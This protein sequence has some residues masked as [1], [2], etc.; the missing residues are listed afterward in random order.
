[1]VRWIWT[2]KQDLGPPGA[3]GMVYDGSSKRTILLINRTTWEWDGASWVELDDMGPAGC[4]ALI[5]DASRKRVISF[6]TKDKKV[7]ETWA[8]DGEE[9]TQLTDTGPGPRAT[10]M[11]YDSARDRI[12]LF[13]GEGLV[14]PGPTAPAIYGDTWESNGEEWTQQEDQGPNARVGHGMIYD[15]ARKQTILFGGTGIQDFGDTWAWD[16]ESWKLQV[17]FGPSP[18]YWHAMAYDGD[19]KQTILFGGSYTV[20]SGPRPVLGDTWGWDGKSW[21]QR[22]DMGPPA[23]SGAVMTYD[24]DRQRTALFGGFGAPDAQGKHPTLRDTWELNLS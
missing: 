13:G 21:I 9:W 10:V 24:S 14:P 15:G 3:E 2:Q 16:G 23:R 1:M 20:A 12:V 22:Q 7:G 18:R 5:Y 4:V 19:A 6:G 17:N 11:A 8:W